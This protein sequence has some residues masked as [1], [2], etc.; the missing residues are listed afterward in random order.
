MTVPCRTKY[1]PTIAR[2]LHHDVSIASVWPDKRQTAGSGP[3]A[4]S[5]L[6]QRVHSAA[7]QISGV[8]ANAT[9]ATHAD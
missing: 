1:K 8:S 7:R 2:K 5:W 4:E 3:D 9:R 6:Y